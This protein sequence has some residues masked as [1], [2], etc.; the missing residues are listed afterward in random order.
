[1]K[2]R[3]LQLIGSFHQGGSE[4][5]AISLARMLKAEG[6]FDVSIATL[7][8]QGVLRAKVESIGFTE[9]PLTSFYNANFVRQVRRFARYLRERHI[10]LIHTHDFYTNVFGMTAATLAGVPVRIAAKRETGE[11]RSRPQEFVETIA[12]SRASAIVANSAAVKSYLIERSVGARKIEVIYSGV[13]LSRFGANP[14]RRAKVCKKLGL[15]VDKSIKFVTMVANL[16]HRVKNVPML[17]RAAKHVIAIRPNTHFVIAGEGELANE[18]EL[19]AEQMKIVRNVHFVG[20]CDDVSSLLSISSVG[21]LTS[22]AEGF[23]NA[24]LEYMAAAK[25]VIATN[26]GG[27]G[28]VMIDGETGYLVESND[29]AKLAEH[30]TTL[31]ADTKLAKKM[32]EA[33]RAVIEKRFDSAKHL[34]EIVGLYAKHL[35]PQNIYGHTAEFSKMEIGADNNAALASQPAVINK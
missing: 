23:S 10:D 11:M 24:V 21:V 12:F 28:E 33:G 22:S 5:Q 20:R 4:R 16:R 8:A 29:D 6:S 18:L 3:V 13:D 7:N 35:A 2:R 9:Y 14:S 17:L 25:P 34:S 32:G 19:I 31:L 30:L 1:M 27:V 15:P 26:V